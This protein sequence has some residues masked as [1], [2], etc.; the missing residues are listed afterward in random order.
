MRANAHLTKGA[1]RESGLKRGSIPFVLIFGSLYQDKEQSHSGKRFE[2]TII[3]R[4]TPNPPYNT[5]L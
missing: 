3:W 5:S 1:G 2:E 4:Q